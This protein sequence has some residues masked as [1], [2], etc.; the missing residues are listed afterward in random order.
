MVLTQ[1]TFT[2]SQTLHKQDLTDV[3]AGSCPLV[4]CQAGS[5]FELELKS[6][7]L[8]HWHE[9]LGRTLKSCHIWTF[10]RM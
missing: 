4:Q 10:D 9:A 3:F 6:A 2:R 1:Y 5:C 7:V 8:P